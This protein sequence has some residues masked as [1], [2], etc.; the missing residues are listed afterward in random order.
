MHRARG[1]RL[2]CCRNC[3]CTLTDQFEYQ[4]I[5][6]FAHQQ[7]IKRYR[8]LF[9][10]QIGASSG[11][12]SARGAKTAAAPAVRCSPSK[13]LREA[14]APL[15]NVALH[16]EV[17]LLYLFMMPWW[18]LYQLRASNSRS[19]CS[20]NRIEAAGQGH[21]QLSTCGQCKQHRPVISGRWHHVGAVCTSSVAAACSCFILIAAAT[22]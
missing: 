13:L 19:S 17:S 7:R 20:S 12:V 21:S 10:K 11:S 3:G 8:Q 5:Q 22:A 1:P 16:A 6:R 9:Y 15:M 2:F 14:R 18:L 4:S